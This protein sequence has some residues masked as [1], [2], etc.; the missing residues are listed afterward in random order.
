MTRQ[1]STTLDQYLTF[2]LGREVFA[3]DIGKVKEVLEITAT[4]EIPGTPDHLRGVINL[5][6]HAVPVV[7]MRLKLGMG[8]IEDTVDTCI[9]ILDVQLGEEKVG[10]GVLDSVVTRLSKQFLCAILSQRTD[11]KGGCLDDPSTQTP[12]HFRRR[13][14]KT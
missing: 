6:G 4:S 11:S 8:R 1:D 9:I 13:L 12:R 5:R 10:M 7:E 14:E 3:L 2:S